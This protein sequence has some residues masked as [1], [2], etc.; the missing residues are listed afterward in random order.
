MLQNYETMVADSSFDLFFGPA[1]GIW[2]VPRPISFRRRFCGFF[3][4]LGDLPERCELLMF[5]F[6]QLG[7]C[8]LVDFS[9]ETFPENCRVLRNILFSKAFL[10]EKVFFFCF[11]GFWKANPS[12]APQELA[13][14]SWKLDV[15]LLSLVSLLF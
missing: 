5:F 1:H 9:L 11:L 2:S 14:G 4:D 7:R 3:G 8:R 15:A 6:K 13:I 10:G 12:F